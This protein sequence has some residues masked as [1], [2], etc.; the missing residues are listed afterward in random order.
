MVFKEVIYKFHFNMDYIIGSGSLGQI[1]WRYMAAVIV[2]QRQNRA[3][4]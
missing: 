4:L 2:C 1:S 3:V